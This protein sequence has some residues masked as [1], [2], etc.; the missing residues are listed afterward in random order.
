[1]FI[2]ILVRKKP[3]S[4]TGSRSGSR[5]EFI[6]PVSLRVKVTKNA[7]KSYIFIPAP[8]DEYILHR[9]A[10]NLATFFISFIY[11]EYISHRDGETLFLYYKEE[12]IKET[13]KYFVFK[14]SIIQLLIFL[15]TLFKD[16]QT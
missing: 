2:E 16:T 10:V 4:G 6:S 1:M 11:R 14:Y 8:H 13:D 9:R 7:K 3:K 5:S 12:K 15:R